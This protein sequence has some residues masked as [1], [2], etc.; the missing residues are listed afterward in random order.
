[1][2]DKPICSVCIANYNGVSTLAACLDSALNQ[3]CGFSVE[4]IVHD[5]ASSDESVA[6]IHQH[7]PRVALIESRENVGFC[8]ANN[9]MAAQAR[10]EFLLLL[11]NDAEL[12]PDALNALYKTAKQLDKP[13][14]IGLPQYDAA[15]GDL[16]DRGSLLDPFLN[17]VPNLNQKRAKNLILACGLPRS[18]VLR[19]YLIPLKSTAVLHRRLSPFVPIRLR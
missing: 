9:R 17:P 6:F 8:V 4:V 14:I 1:M 19:C 15:T 10:G 11:N 3:D 16:I 7:Y 13:A 12:F 5:D 2:K 18:I